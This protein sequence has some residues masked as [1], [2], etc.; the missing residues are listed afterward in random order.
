MTANLALMKC[1]DIGAAVIP[2]ADLLAYLLLVFRVKLGVSD[3]DTIRALG[4]NRSPWINYA[5]AAKRKLSGHLAVLIN[6]DN[7]SQVEKGCA[8]DKGIPMIGARR[9]RITGGEE[10]RDKKNIGAILNHASGKF[11]KS[12]VIADQDADSADIGIKYCGVRARLNKFG[13][14]IAHGFHKMDLIILTDDVTVSID[15]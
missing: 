10:S 6:G 3:A 9:Q 1:V 13:L 4:D 15:K 5:T 7:V 14:I 8:V 2:T 11:G 12:Q